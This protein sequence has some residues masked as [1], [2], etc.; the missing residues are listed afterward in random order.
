MTPVA[1][2]IIVGVIILLSTVV[3][4]MRGIIKEMFTIFGLFIAAFIAYKGG[5]LLL[6]DV[7]TWLHVPED[8][9]SDKA[10]YVLFGILSPAM[11][12]RA[13]SY[14]GTFAT[15]LL[16]VTLLGRMFSN[17]VKEAGMEIVDKCLGASFG[18][19]RGFLVVFVMYVPFNYLIDGD[20]FPDWAKKSYSVSVFDKTFKWASKEFKLDEKIEEKSD[21]VVIKFSKIEANKKLKDAS[22][23][24]SFTDKVTETIG[25]AASS[26]TDSI[27]SD[28][29][30]S[31]EE[32]P[33]REEKKSE[34][35][36]ETP[37]SNDSSKATFTTPLNEGK[38]SPDGVYK[39]PSVSSEDLYDPNKADVNNKGSEEY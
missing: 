20:E 12:A 14:G 16:I 32:K 27:T 18:F 5:H 35:K 29:E 11:A 25:E 8:G 1:L 6:P 39:D 34:T 38:T 37:A 7:N 9:I 3:A 15:V 33:V 10:D 30:N 22:D 24:K 19:L 31:A 28:D 13:I 21:G 23:E 26:I 4:Y 17:W 2:D 36:S